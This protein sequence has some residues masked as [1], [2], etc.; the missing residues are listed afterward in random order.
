M[1]VPRPR[2]GHG[3]D[4]LKTETRERARARRMA[5]LDRSPGRA[6]AIARLREARWLWVTLGAGLVLLVLGN[7]KLA[8]SGMAVMLAMVVL[9]GL[10]NDLATGLSRLLP[11]VP[12]PFV[13]RPRV[14]PPVVAALFGLGGFLVV[15]INGPRVAEEL[16][17]AAEI[18]IVVLLLLRWGL[19]NV[20]GGG[21]RDVE[22]SE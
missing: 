22:R 14:F 9:A 13:G 18:A 21:A 7:W 4:G 11:I 3:A 2:R 12:R 19:R 8:V 1:A 15:L 20:F 6:A 10:V 17:F 5:A 16:A